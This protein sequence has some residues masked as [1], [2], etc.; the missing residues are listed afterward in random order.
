[1]RFS[2]YTVKGEGWQ[3]M[4]DIVCLNG[5][6]NQENMSS[7]HNHLCQHCRHRLEDRNQHV[8]A[9][10]GG[11]VYTAAEHGGTDLLAIH[12][13]LIVINIITTHTAPDM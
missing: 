8:C 13:N 3:G 2:H 10:G 4:I 1:M 12:S 9:W 6:T 11:N 7:N 5:F